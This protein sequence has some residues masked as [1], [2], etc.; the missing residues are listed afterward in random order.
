MH[1]LMYADFIIPFLEANNKKLP[2]DDEHLRRCMILNPQNRI[3]FSKKYLEFAEQLLSGNRYLLDFQ[4]FFLELMDGPS[5]RFENLPCSETSTSF[6]EEFLHLARNNSFEFQLAISESPVP[7]FPKMVCYSQLDKP[8]YHW[9]LTQLA[10]FHMVS[11]HRRDFAGQKY[12]DVFFDDLFSLPIKMNEVYYFDRKCSNSCRH[13][14]FRKLKSINHPVN[15]YTFGSKF[16]NK[17][18]VHFSASDFSKLKSN[19][20]TAL[21]N[22][23]RLFY[24]HANNLSHDRKILFN[25]LTIEPNHDFGELKMTNTTWKVDLTYSQDLYH[26]QIER[27]KQFIEAE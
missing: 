7:E 13:N 3:L 4:M 15:V 14:Y 12:I 22:S 1:I 21:G 10:A 26:S 18:N 9:T 8:N 5:N 11:V 23:L 20:N 19:L 6:K 25:Y 17:M 16:E 24:T 2:K 27:T